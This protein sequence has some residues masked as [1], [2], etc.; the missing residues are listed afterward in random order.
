MRDQPG[1]LDRGGVAAPICGPVIAIA[2]DPDDRLVVRNH[3]QRGFQV[4]D[5]PL[6]AGDRAGLIVVGVLVIIHQQHAV[7]DAAIGGQ[8]PVLVIDRNGQRD[9]PVVCG[10]TGP[11]LGQKVLVIALS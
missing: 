11:G 8:I 4:I 3:L 1:F 5:K 2:A 10:I 9:Q 7:G 6:L